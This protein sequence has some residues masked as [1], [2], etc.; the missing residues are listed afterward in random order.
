MAGLAA[1]RSGDPA[2]VHD[3]MQIKVPDGRMSENMIRR[4]GSMHG[5]GDAEAKRGISPFPYP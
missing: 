3:L 1:R 5:G 4:A 2:A